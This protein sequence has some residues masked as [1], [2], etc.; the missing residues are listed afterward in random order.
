MLILKGFG[1]PSSVSA[2]VLMLRLFKYLSSIRYGCRAFVGRRSVIWHTFCE[3]SAED[4]RLI[5][6]ES[7]LSSL[8]LFSISSLSASAVDLLPLTVFG[9]AS[10]V[11]GWVSAFSEESV[12]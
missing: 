6:S 5:S 11:D 7:F 4:V 12:D 1:L 9:T 8:S 3:V 2:G 10:E